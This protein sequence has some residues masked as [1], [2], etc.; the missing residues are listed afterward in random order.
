MRIITLAIVGA[1]MVWAANSALAAKRHDHNSSTTLQ[2]TEQDSITSPYAPGQQRFR[3]E[4]HK[5]K[6]LH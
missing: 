2:K 6:S 5:R 3:R 4:H 1:L